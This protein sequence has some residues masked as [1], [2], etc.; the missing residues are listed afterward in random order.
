[1]QCTSA[2]VRLDKINRPSKFLGRG[3]ERLKIIHIISMPIFENMNTLS[4]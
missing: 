4:H 2:H 1:M 3:L